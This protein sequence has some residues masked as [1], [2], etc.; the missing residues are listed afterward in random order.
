M[1]EMVGA[2]VSVELTPITAALNVAPMH[3]ETSAGFIEKLGV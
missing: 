2:V 1:L 3:T